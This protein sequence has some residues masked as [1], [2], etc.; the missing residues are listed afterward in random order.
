[1]AQTVRIALDLMGGDQ[2][3]EIVVPGAAIARERR[4]DIRYLLYGREG[5]VAALID[6]YAEVRDFS[7][8]HHTDVAV[9]M[10][11]KPSQ[12]LRAGRWKSSMWLALEAVK[13]KAADVAVSAGN[14]GALMALRK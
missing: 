11:D 13:Q 14:T 10:E 3:P 4:P 6:R 12:A 5:E 7:V 2:G 9:R 1:M 8:L